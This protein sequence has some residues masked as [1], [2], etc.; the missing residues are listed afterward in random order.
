MPPRAGNLPQPCHSARGESLPDRI[1]GQV[2]IMVALRP[3]FRGEVAGPL[4]DRRRDLGQVT[5]DLR[6]FRPVTPLFA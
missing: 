6:L 5:S 2:T 1:H 4:A 3:L